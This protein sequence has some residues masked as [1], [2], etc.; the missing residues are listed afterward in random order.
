MPDGDAVCPSYRAQCSDWF[1][2]I[3][4]HSFES[5]YS[6]CPR[7]GIYCCKPKL[8]VEAF[9]AS[10]HSMLEPIGIIHSSI[11]V[12]EQNHHPN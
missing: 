8:F 1:K 12:A 7:V 2:D 5:D 11:L 9:L 4:A 6:T 3:H 10:Q